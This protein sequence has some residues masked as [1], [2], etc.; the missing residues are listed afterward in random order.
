[1]K[2]AGGGRGVVCA[3]HT[4]IGERK[5][6][7]RCCLAL[8]VRS[9]TPFVIRRTQLTRRGTDLQAPKGSARYG[10]AIRVRRGRQRQESL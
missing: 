3:G 9:G 1:M 7:D 6:F 2:L 10:G 8:D 4:G 5:L